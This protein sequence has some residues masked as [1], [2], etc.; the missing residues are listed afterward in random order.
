[1]THLL[2]LAF[3]TTY[4]VGPVEAVTIAA[5][6]GYDMV[7]LR[8]LPAAPTEGAYPVMTDPALQREV[9]AALADTGV[10]LADIEIVRLK[11]DTDVAGFQAFCALGQRFGARNV[12]VAGDDPDHARLSDT[13]GRFA[14]LAARHGLT[15]DLEFMPWTGV[16]NLAAA[17]AIVENAGAENGGVLI[18]ALHFDRSDSTLDD[19]RALP[20][21]RIHYAQLCDGPVPYDPSDEGLIH[22]ARAERM[23]P[24]TGGIDLVG[25]VQ[26]LPADTVLSVEV[27]MHTTARTQSA[28]TRA[29]AAIEASRRVIAQARP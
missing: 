4:D 22:I 9:A 17:R 25:M 5:N 26:A 11:P 8:F 20:A 27:P 7:G 28:E 19:I 13:F 14:E 24:G 16:K 29:R 23:L 15:A 21:K 10:Q 2:S 18:D 3:L 1:M 12:L 6:T